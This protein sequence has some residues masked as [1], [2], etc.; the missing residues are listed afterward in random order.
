MKICIEYKKEKI[1]ITGRWRKSE[2]LETL[3]HDSSLERV[4]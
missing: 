1:N 4:C 3:L 2:I